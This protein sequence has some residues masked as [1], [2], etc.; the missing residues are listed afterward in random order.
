MGSRKTDRELRLT[1]VTRA[2]MSP[3]ASGG[4]SGNPF[5]EEDL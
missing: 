4:R 5:T 3:A 2:A 1:P